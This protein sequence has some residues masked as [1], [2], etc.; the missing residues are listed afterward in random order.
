MQKT[1]KAKPHKEPIKAPLPATAKSVG[2][3]IPKIG[4]KGVH[5]IA[6]QKRLKSRPPQGS[7]DLGKIIGKT[8]YAKVFRA[9][10]NGIEVAIKVCHKPRVKLSANT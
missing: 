8:R 7:L 9:T 4:Y 10:L 2:E 3:E 5:T 1:T 6:R